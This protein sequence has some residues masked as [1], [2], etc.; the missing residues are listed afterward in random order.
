MITI[1][2]IADQIKTK[3]ERKN[4]SSED[5]YVNEWKP[6][7]C[8]DYTLPP[9]QIPNVRSVKSTRDKLSKVLA[10]I[11]WVKHKRLARGCTIMPIACTNKRLM[12][13]CGGQRNVSNLIDFMI[14]IGLLEVESDQYQYNATLE[15]YNH[16]KE[17]RYYYENERKIAIYCENND[18]QKKLVKNKD[19]LYIHTVV[20]KFDDI[21]C[22]DTAKV[23][24]SSKLNLVKPD[25]FSKSE[26]EEYLTNALYLNYP[27][28]AYYQSMADE[29]NAT[30]YADDPPL[31]I[32]FIPHFTWT[33]NNKAVRKIGI[34][35]TNAFVS[36]KGEKDGNE[37]F[38][39][40]Y[41]EDVLKK[42][43]LN[44]EK[45]VS[46]S[47]PR[48]TLSLNT[49]MWI[50]EQMDVYRKIYDEYVKRKTESEGLVFREKIPPFEKVRSAIKDLHMRGYFDGENTIGVHTRRVMAEVENKNEVDEEMKLLQ[51]A[52]ISAEGGHLYGSEI[53]YHESCI[54][55]E[56]LKEL[57]ENGYKVWQ[58]Y[59]AWYAAKDGITQ[60]E[61]EEYVTDLVESKAN[62][63]IKRQHL[64][65][66]IVA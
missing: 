28:L 44:L 3:K 37:R 49:G 39:G 36:S 18:I 23:K 29:I 43:G 58:C 61:F 65:E 25:G 17:Y 14:K 21:N 59:D 13:I 42:Y 4:E 63:Y 20:E 6:K 40:Y 55:M 47:V 51:N 1:V 5:K 53:F 56:V 19:Y 64:Q 10:F 9:F 24:F 50:S 46:S 48:I 16:S 12:D 32:H 27:E 62:G 33:K 57:L 38:N 22:F 26:F 30:Y 2:E 35:A 8:T 15:G 54:Y 52:I 41:K 7:E 60:D 11:D 31:T 45:D 66:Q 34:R